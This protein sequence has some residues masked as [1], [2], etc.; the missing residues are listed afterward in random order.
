MEQFAV[1]IESGL[2]QV[3]RRLERK[4]RHEPL[5]EALA[6]GATLASLFFCLPL[7]VGRR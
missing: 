5:S 1:H 6:G 3:V 2:G 7:P 4:V